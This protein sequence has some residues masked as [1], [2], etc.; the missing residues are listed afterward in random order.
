[1]DELG[2]LRRAVVLAQVRAG[3]D[4]EDEV[5]LVPYPG[6]RSFVE[7]LTGAV[8]ARAV[9]RQTGWLTSPYARGAYAQ[10]AQ[11]DLAGQGVPLV[12]MPGVAGGR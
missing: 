1:V 12:L 10:W 8:M 11:M 6:P 3:I 4:A 9:G 5:T 7:V 2:G